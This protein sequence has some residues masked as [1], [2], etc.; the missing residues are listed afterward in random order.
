[1]NR[2]LET[3]WC[4][5][6]RQEVG[7][8]LTLVGV[9]SGAMLVGSFPITLPKL[10]LSVKAITDR[11]Q[12]FRFLT[13]RLFKDDDQW[14]ELHVSE[15]ELEQ[16][17]LAAQAV[18]ASL[19]SQREPTYVVTLNFAVAPFVITAPCTLRAR[20]ETEGDELKGLSLVVAQVPESSIPT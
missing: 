20:A 1:M 7:G 2:Q 19:P 12:P 9:Y 5:D 10:C 6:I 8:K 17:T 13:L 11:N 15:T 18:T 3:T 16:S 4:D 14:Q